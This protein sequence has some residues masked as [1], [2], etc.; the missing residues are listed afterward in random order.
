MSVLGNNS[1]MF[2][3]PSAFPDVKENIELYS[4]TWS[5]HI[6]V[7][8]PEI[9]DPE[10]VRSTISN[11][12]YVAYSKPGPNQTHS[13]NLVFVSDVVRL[14]SARLHVFV[15]SPAHRPKVSTALFSRKPHHSNVVWTNNVQ[16]S[17]D[18]E[19]DVLYIS[20]QNAVPAFSEE[21]EDGLLFRYAISDDTPCGVTVIAFRAGWS[22]HEEALAQRVS[23]FLKVPALEAARALASIH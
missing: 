5:Q 23:D 21:E 16:M 6:Q 13:E 11:P 3:E 22:S 12:S 17:Y 14:K 7:R 18:A 20:K 9:A 4:N 2:S 19:G 8:H 15:E 1:V 10:Q